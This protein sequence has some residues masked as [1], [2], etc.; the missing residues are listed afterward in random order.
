MIELKVVT[1]THFADM[2]SVEEFLKGNG[3]FEPYQINELLDDRTLHIDVEDPNEAVIG[4]TT[5][6]FTLKE[7]K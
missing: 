3:A 1:T 6:V 4:E 2:E 7:V 5:N